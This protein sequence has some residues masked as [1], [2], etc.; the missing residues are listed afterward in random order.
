M[1]KVHCC[2]SYLTFESAARP[3]HCPS[4]RCPIKGSIKCHSNSIPATLSKLSCSA[5]WHCFSYSRPSYP[6]EQPARLVDG[7]FT[8][9]VAIEQI[10]V[11]ICGS[12]QRWETARHHIM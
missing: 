6:P 10:S 1:K 4:A 11:E 2:V 7:H 8:S 12:R 5:G 9:C 3:I